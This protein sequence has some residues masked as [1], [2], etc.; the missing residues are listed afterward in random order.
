MMEDIKLFKG[1]AFDKNRSQYIVNQIDLTFEEYPN[2]A[3]Y[4][5]YLSDFIFETIK[6]LVIKKHSNK[7]NCVDKKGTEL[8]DQINFIE[9]FLHYYCDIKCQRNKGENVELSDEMSN[10][11]HQTNEETMLNVCNYLN[12]Q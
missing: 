2:F 8:I 5:N 11:F 3:G 12:G 9:G 1:I 4:I 10:S 7:H 6:L